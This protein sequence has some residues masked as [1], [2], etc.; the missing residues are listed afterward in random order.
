MLYYKR[1]Q[2]RE[3]DYINLLRFKEA[4]TMFNYEF[5]EYEE[6]RDLA[7]SPLAYV[8]LNCGR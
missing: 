3:L 5:S 2:E 1:N 8:V 4:T 6:N 7:I